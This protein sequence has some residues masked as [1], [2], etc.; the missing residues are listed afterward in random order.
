MPASNVEPASPEP[1]TLPKSSFLG[2]AAYIAAPGTAVIGLLYYIGSTYNN[3][4]YSSFGVPE[5]DLQFSVQDHLVKSTLAVL[6]PL[7]LLLACGLVVV[8]TFGWIKQVLARPGNEARRS[9]VIRWLLGLGLLTLVMGFLVTLLDWLS[10]LDAWVRQLLPPLMVALGASMAFLAVQLRL[11]QGRGE[12]NLRP[13][14]GDRMWLEAGALLIGLVAVSLFV[15]AGRYTRLLGRTDA[16]RAGE[17]GYV[18]SPSVVI[19][20][21]VPITHHAYGILYV[22]LGSGSGPYRHQYRGFRILVKAPTRFYLVSYAARFEDRVMVVLP[23]DDT[24]RVEIK[25]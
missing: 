16:I 13:L 10:P 24:L 8:L 15:D 1:H 5:A 18:G 21:K 3:A 19:Y 20:S 11:D 25:P 2:R 14:T 23:D 4:Y 6:L 12:G 7:W 17:T 9:L 22:D